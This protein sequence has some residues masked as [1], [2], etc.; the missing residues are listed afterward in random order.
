MKVQTRD[1]SEKIYVHE[2]DLESDTEQET[3]VQVTT[4][5]NLILSDSIL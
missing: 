4:C 3:N 2:S 1:D 5:D